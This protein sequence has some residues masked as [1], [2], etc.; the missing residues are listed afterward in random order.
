MGI[1][2]KGDP[3]AFELK[4]GNIGVLLIHG[5]TGS[6]A[7][8]RLVGQY[9]NERGLTVSAPLLPGH[10]TEVEDLNQIRW[11]ELTA[12]VETALA[13]LQERCQHTFVAG[14]SMGGLLT[15]YLGSRHPEL[16]GITTYAAALDIADWRRHFAPIIKRLFKTISKQE[17]HWADPQAED[18]MW[19]YDVWPVGGAMQLFALRDEVESSLPRITC[20]ALII[21]ST[22][23][24]TVTPE[25]AG[26]I[27]DAIASEDKELVRL[28]E[29]GHVMTVDRGWDQLAERTYQFIMA[30]V[31]ETEEVTSS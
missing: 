7:E 26:M 16:P 20:P 12:A 10:G 11:Q 9:L 19:A 8:M 22:A 28:D 29:C 4:G 2:G 18:L 17:E 3:S 24:S 13:K 31:P 6:P 1:I 27:V 25:A 5:F 30:R 21:Y 23:D 15:L 14:L